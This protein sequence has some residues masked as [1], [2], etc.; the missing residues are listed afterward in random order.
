MATHSSVLAWRTSGTE[1]PGG[2]LSMW[3]HR[4]RH[5]WSNAAAAAHRTQE[6]HLLTKLPVN[7]KIIK[8]Y[9]ST[10]RWRDT[11][12][13]FLNKG[14]SIPTEFGPCRVVRGSI[15]IPQ[16]GSPTN[17]ILWWFYRGHN[18]YRH[19]WLNNWPQFNLQSLSSPFPGWEWKVLTHMVGFLGTQPP[20]KTHLNN[21]TKDNFIILIT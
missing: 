21:I 14:A 12:G 16:H 20:S 8:G 6:V 19:D 7:C 10:A 11:Y 18:K 2:L 4:V 15:L 5:D 1:E 17:L 3:S 13:K 9:Q